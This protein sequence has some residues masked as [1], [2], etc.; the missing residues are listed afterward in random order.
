MDDDLAP[1]CWP[2]HA[3]GNAEAVSVVKQK[4]PELTWEVPPI[5][6]WHLR[7]LNSMVLPGWLVLF[8]PKLPG[9]QYSSDQ[10]KID[11]SNP[12]GLALGIYYVMF[13]GRKEFIQIIMGEDQEF[14]MQLSIFDPLNTMVVTGSQEN[15][16]F[17]ENMRYGDQYHRGPGW[18]SWM[19]RWKYRNGQWRHGAQ[20]E[21]DALEAQRLQKYTNYGK[22]IQIYY[23]PA[24]NMEDKIQNFVKSFQ[25]S[26]RLYNT[27]KEFWDNVDFSDTRLIRTP[28][29][30]INWN[31]FSKS[32]PFSIRTASWSLH[33]NWWPKLWTSPNIIK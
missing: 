23:L 17:Y 20:K 5:W 4:E 29:F 30:G 9:R 11:Y 8:R 1:F 28:M 25:K 3:G 7:F 6:P 22:S 13:T 15:E 33:T 24:T 14:D 19:P 32:W 27:A 10:W 31:D 16:L 21:R 2:C 12:K 26:C 18:M